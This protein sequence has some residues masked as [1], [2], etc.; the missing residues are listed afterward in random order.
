MRRHECL[1]SLARLDCGN[2]SHRDGVSSEALLYPQNHVKIVQAKTNPAQNHKA[3]DK[4]P[5]AQLYV[6]R[7]A[8]QPLRFSLVAQEK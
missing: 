3:F 1:L 7:A 5:R 8:C 2:E 4:K 6:F